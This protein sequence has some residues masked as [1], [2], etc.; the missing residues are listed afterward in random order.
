MKDEKE[1]Q[2]VCKVEC[3][4]RYMMPSRIQSEELHIKHVGHPCQ[5]M[6]VRGIGG[7]CCPED[8]LHRYT[9]LNMIVF[10]YIDGI[11]VINKI[12]T[13]DLPECHEG[14]NC[15]GH[16]KHEDLLILCHKTILGD[17]PV[18]FRRNRLPIV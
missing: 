13:I 17:A 11:V 18:S 4:V 9:M 16:A 14:N 2:R 7:R 5:R 8:P 6:P 12:A 3:E 10:C 1:Q 15:Q